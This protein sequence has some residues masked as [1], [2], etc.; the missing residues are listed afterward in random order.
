MITTENYWIFDKKFVFKPGFNEILIDEYYEVMT[1]C[2]TL[3]FANYLNPYV[4]IET[5]NQYLNKHHDKWIGSKFNQSFNLPHN[6][7]N[8]ILGEHF[9]QYINLH[10]NLTHLTL[11]ISFEQQIELPSSIKYLNLNSNTNLINYLP[12]SV[13]I[14]E[15]GDHFDI[16]LLNLPNSIK[17]IIFN[18]RNCYSHYLNCLPQSVEYIE[19][20]MYYKKK[21]SNIPKSLKKV[22]HYN[23][24]FYPYPLPIEYLEF[25]KKSNLN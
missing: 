19:L 20:P 18:E 7:T 9:N 1:N 17:K 16:E 24:Y 4:S 10:S 14:L 12:S 8:L 23:E 22:F 5:N 21:I 15:L 25:S 13:E 6:I 11:G 2:D 3:V